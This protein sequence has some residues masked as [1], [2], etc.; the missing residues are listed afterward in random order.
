MKKNLIVYY[1]RRGENY[2]DGG[3]RVLEEGNTAKAAKLIAAAVG[4]ELFEVDTVKPYAEGY[5]ACCGEAVA[6]WKSGAR[7]EIKG[8]AENMDSYDTIFVGYPIWCGTMPMCMYTFLE[9]YDLVGKTIVPFCTHEGSGFGTSLQDLER[10]CPGAVIG[11]AMEV[12]GCAVDES[13]ERIAA[14]AKEQA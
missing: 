9:H 8:Y 4:G 3:L 2:Y 1:S 6:E 14:W 13:A 12:K 5:R 10:I 11:S 7:P